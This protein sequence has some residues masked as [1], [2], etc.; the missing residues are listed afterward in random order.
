MMKSGF[1]VIERIRIDT[2]EDA[3]GAVELPD[4]CAAAE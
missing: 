2:I 4:E 1:G 3:P